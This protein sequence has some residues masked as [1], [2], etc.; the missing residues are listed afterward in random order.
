[1]ATKNS[2]I[3]GFLLGGL[4]A[5]GTGLA[6]FGALRNNEALLI[7][8]VCIVCLTIPYVFYAKALHEAQ[9]EVE[10][11]EREA[12][13]AR[14]KN[15]MLMRERSWTAQ[16]LQEIYNEPGDEGLVD[17]W[18]FQLREARVVIGDILKRY[19][20]VDRAWKETEGQIEEVKEPGPPERETRRDIP[21]PPA[22]L[23]TPAL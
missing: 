6:M 16:Y 11:W 20:E 1:M 15:D 3:S 14:F 7:I 9:L 18:R 5:I 12:N 19:K 13:K 8:G 22:G 17:T 2:Y 10:V 21:K 4:I 23:N